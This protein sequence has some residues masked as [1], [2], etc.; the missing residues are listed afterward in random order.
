M[1]TNT[2]DIDYKKIP[3]V[4]NVYKPIGPS[5]FSVVQ[6]FK[7][8]L[9]YDYG[10]I[11]HFGTLDPFAEGVLLIGVQGAQKMNEYIHQLLPKTYRAVGC[12]GVKTDSG[13]FETAVIAEKHIEENFQ[14]FSVN[15][16]DEKLRSHFLGEY[17][18]APHKYSASKFE[19]KRM[20][21]LALKGKE[22]TKEKV[23]REIL[24]FKILNYEYPTCEFSVTVSSGTY[25]RSLF[26]E[27]STLLGGYG[28]L[29]VLERTAIGENLST[30]SIKESDWPKRSELFDLK[31]WGTPLDH[32]LRLDSIIL[33]IEQTKTY[34]RGHRFRLNEVQ[35]VA[36]D[37]PTEIV[38]DE[39]Y[40]VYSENKHLLGLARPVAL[41]LHSLFNLK[42]AI[43]TFIPESVCYK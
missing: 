12:F 20:Y 33:P 19:G 35:I 9:N 7:K 28:S 11:G 10:K 1:T 31:R 21:D 17:W 4:F 16:L 42:E 43:E 23:K 14:K 32:A 3:L 8:N 34:L 41:E 24:D 26:E 37:H 18:Q 2:S 40:W 36:N 27:I 39:L 13:D 15:E 22:V 25:I 5:S 30:N 6:H 29:K 38:S